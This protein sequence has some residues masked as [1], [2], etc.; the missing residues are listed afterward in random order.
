MSPISSRKS[1]PPSAASSRPIFRRRASV[2]AP[3]SWPNSSDSSSGSGTAEQVIDTKG[4]PARA[5][6]AWI[7]RATSPLPLPLSPS[8]STARA[9]EAAMRRIWSRSA[10]TTGEVPRKPSAPAPGSVSRRSRRFSR[11]R[12]PVSSAF[13][14]WASSASASTGFST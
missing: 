1:V 14:T 12:S 8:S 3:A 2:K 6:S 7:A 11:R 4:R 9:G 10:T 13:S 5:L